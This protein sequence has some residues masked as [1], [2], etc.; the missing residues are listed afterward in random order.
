MIYPRLLHPGDTVAVVAPAG[1]CD[2]IRLA[3]GVRVLQSLGLRCRIMDSCRTNHTHPDYLSAPDALRAHDLHDAFA[4]PTIRAVFAAR[5]GYGTQRLL[6]LLDFD[7]IKR[8]PKIFTG[9]SDIT[10]L[11]TAF[12]VH[13]RMARSFRKRLQFVV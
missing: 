7:L 10:A 4:D 13:A 11:H 12:E 5:G 1:P 9:Y 2:P 6:P 8:N 3:R